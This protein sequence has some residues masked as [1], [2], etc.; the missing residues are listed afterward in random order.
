MTIWSKS[1]SVIN[2]I[3]Y[4]PL[5]DTYILLN[6]WNISNVQLSYKV[7]A[8]I[9][10]CNVS[11]ANQQF[12]ELS[13]FLTP[14]VINFLHPLYSIIDNFH[15]SM[16]V[17]VEFMILITYFGKWVKLLCIVYWL[18][19]KYN[20]YFFHYGEFTKKGIKFVNLLFHC[21]GTKALN[22]L[23]YLII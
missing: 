14:T 13:F 11:D 19:V 17:S 4:L 21:H 18:S 23:Y 1:Y 6:L 15:L 10:I 9:L 2:K 7:Y 20:L 22:V 3:T 16:R 12:S 8:V 5:V